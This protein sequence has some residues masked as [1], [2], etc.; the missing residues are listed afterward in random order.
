[1]ADWL[2]QM[3]AGYRASHIGSSFDKQLDLYR[4]KISQAEDDLQRMVM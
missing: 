3:I 1:M 2:N 4:S